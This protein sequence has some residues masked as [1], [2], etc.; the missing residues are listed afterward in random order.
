MRFTSSEI[1]NGVSSQRSVLNLPPGYQNAI[2]AVRFARK[3]AKIFQELLLGKLTI[4]KDIA[5]TS[6]IRQG[7]LLIL[8]FL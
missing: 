3:T 5:A 7:F 1:K 8:N 6:K 2:N 4:L